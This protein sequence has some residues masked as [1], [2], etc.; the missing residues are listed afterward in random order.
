MYSDFVVMERVVRS[1][2]AAFINM[3]TNVDKTSEDFKS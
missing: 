1:E 3:T 2:E